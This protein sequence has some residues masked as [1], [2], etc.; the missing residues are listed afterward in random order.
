MKSLDH[1]I[2]NSINLNQEAQL[3]HLDKLLI[4]I[5]KAQERHLVKKHHVWTMK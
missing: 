4:D 5:L 3:N 1:D 2:K